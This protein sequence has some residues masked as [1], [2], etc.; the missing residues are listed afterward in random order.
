MNVTAV[1]VMADGSGTRRG[2]ICRRDDGRFQYVTETLTD[3]TGDSLPCWTNDHPPSGIFERQ[4]EA[5]EALAAEFSAAIRL[6]GADPVSFDASV[7]PY[8]E[9]TFAKRR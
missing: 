4:D 2:R 5:A 1:E 9:P 6:E 3:A 8:P 7:G